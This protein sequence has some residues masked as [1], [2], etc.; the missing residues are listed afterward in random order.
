[1]KQTRS[2]AAFVMLAFLV[3]CGGGPPPPKDEFYRLNVVAP[4]TTF[5][6]PVLNGT[7]EV[8]RLHADGVTIERAI[9]YSSKKTQL[10]QY[11]YHYWTE[12]PVRLLQE[13]LVD[14]LRAAKVAP[15][16]VTPEHRAL[17]DYNV[18]GKVRRFE[19]LREGS[20]R[21]VVEVE[22]TVQ[23]ASDGQVLL[24]ETY[25]VE[26]PASDATVPAAA[27]AMS[28]AVGALSER[29]LADLAKLG[30]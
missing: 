12:T 26:E 25:M 2:L 5:P 4:S 9:A 24:L 27:E 22:L 1:M 29:F 8:S 20:P 18:L 16:V 13:A 30:S 19:H 11:A 15:L 10:T 21:V 28:R 17:S 6:T 3:S 14:Q 7:V 23:N